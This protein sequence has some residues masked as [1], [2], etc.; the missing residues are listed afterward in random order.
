V[1]VALLL[2]LAQPPQPN[3]A[4]LIDRGT[5]RLRAGDLDGALA[6]FDEAIRLRPSSARAFLWRGRAWT[7][8]GDLDRAL[9]DFNQAIKFDPLNDQA[10]SGRGEVG[11]VLLSL[12]GGVGQPLG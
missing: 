5:T 10:F 6:A 11:D 7:Q 2:A 9:D 8:K 3:A 12:H 1:F 4:T